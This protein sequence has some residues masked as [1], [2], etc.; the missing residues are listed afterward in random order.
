LE[1]RIDRDYP[2]QIGSLR[3]SRWAPHF[4]IRLHVRQLSTIGVLKTQVDPVPLVRFVPPN[5]NSDG[6]AEMVDRWLTCPGQKSHRC[7]HWE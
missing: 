7:P 3:Q 4:K 2:A 6:D 5:Q 1:F